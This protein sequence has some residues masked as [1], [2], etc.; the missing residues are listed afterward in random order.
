MEDS[1]EF[2]LKSIYLSSELRCHHRH[3]INCTWT[4][5][6]HFHFPPHY[7]NCWNIDPFAHLWNYFYLSKI[8]L[9]LDDANHV[10]WKMLS[11]IYGHVIFA[12]VFVDFYRTKMMR[13]CCHLNGSG[14]LSEC[15]RDALA[16][17]YCFCHYFVSFYDQIHRIPN[18]MSRGSYIRHFR[19]RC[20]H[21]HSLETHKSYH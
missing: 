21:R 18:R 7:W 5:P 8:S 6:R 14:I 20:S 15:C 11:L 1:V 10:H 2:E 9:C 12:S 16:T 17:F 13:N 19:V 3:R 4:G